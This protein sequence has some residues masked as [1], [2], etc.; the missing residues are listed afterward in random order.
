[1]NVKPQHFRPNSDKKTRAVKAVQ[2]H[3]ANRNRVNID[4]LWQAVRRRTH[5][6]YADTFL[7]RIAADLGW[8]LVQED[9][10]VYFERPYRLTM[11]GWLEQQ[12]EKEPLI[13][14][15]GGHLDGEHFTFNH[16][17]RLTCVSLDKRTTYHL[18]SI[19]DAGTPVPV[20]VVEGMGDDEALERYTSRASARA[21][22]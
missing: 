9:G 7:A 11:Q 17:T 19:V 18:R 5:A 20:Y 21:V 6:C 8:Q 1:M 4:E 22:S 3:F 13:L 15:I 16:G 12:R 14:C 2:A 10:D